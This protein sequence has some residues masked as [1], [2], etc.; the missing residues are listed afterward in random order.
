MATTLED[1]YPWLINKQ[2]YLSF[3]SVSGASCVLFLFSPS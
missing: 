1:T 2:G 3:E